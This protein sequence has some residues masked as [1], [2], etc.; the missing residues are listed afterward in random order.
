MNTQTIAVVNKN[1]TLAAAIAR[2]IGSKFDKAEI[3]TVDKLSDAPQGS[4]LASLGLPSYVPSANIAQVISVGT[5]ICRTED[6]KTKQWDT[7]KD[8]NSTSEDLLAELGSFEQY[9]ILPSR[10]T[11]D[12]R[13]ELAEARL[14]I[15]EATNVEEERDAYKAAFETLRNKIPGLK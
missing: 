14:A 5:K 13:L 7:I 2:H 3:V 10:A 1:K 9:F 6:E 4:I 12:I 15:A 8:E 11:Q